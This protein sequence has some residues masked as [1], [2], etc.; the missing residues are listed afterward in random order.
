[1]IRENTSRNFLI[2]EL[3][4]K[5]RTIDE[6]AF[7]TA[8]PRSTVGYYIRKFNK[9]AKSGEP[10][11]FQQAR[12][13]PDEKAIA[14]QAFVKNSAFL[15]LSKMLMNGEIDKVYKLLMILKLWKEL[16]R[17]IFPTIEEAEAFLKSL[18]RVTE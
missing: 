1:M 13:Q 9:R 16:Q 3:W 2:Y 6:I 8:I 18:G 5:G 12:E 7:E 11:A 15:N 17:D 14:V 10:I 4:K